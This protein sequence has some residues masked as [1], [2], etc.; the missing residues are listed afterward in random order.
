MSGTWGGSFRFR[1]RMTTRQLLCVCTNIFYVLGGFGIGKKGREIGSGS[2]GVNVRRGSENSGMSHI[3]DDWSYAR[4][5]WNTGSSGSTGG[6]CSRLRRGRTWLIMTLPG[7]ERSGR[8]SLLTH[9]DVCI[10]GKVSTGNNTRGRYPT[11]GGQHL[12][13]NNIIKLHG[14]RLVNGIWLGIRIRV[15]SLIGDSNTKYLPHPNIGIC[16]PLNYTAFRGKQR[17]SNKG[18]IGIY[19]PIIKLILGNMQ[20][21]VWIREGKR[22]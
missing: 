6:R 5:I 19:G 9:E 7:R 22:Y 16:C 18:R 13:L 4:N 21:K 11:S 12:G 20:E 14:K 3:T 8:H 2:V 15:V 1:G 17:G 10:T